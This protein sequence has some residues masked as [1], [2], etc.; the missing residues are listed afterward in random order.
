M[1]PLPGDGFHDLA[2]RVVQPI[3]AILAGVGGEKKPSKICFSCSRLNE[4]KVSSIID[5]DINDDDDGYNDGYDDDIDTTPLF[6]FFLTLRQDFLWA[7]PKRDRAIKK[8]EF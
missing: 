4:K 8:F 6:L 2:Q 1:L 5:T 7:E 3:R